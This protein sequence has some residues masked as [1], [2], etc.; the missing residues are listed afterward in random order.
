MH[1]VEKL[2]QIGI[3][4]NGNFTLKSGHSSN[5]YFNMKEITNH[6]T[7]MTDIC[8]ELSKLVIN[9]C[10]VC[11]A[12]VPMGA[13]PFATMVSYIKS[14][15]MMLVRAEKKEYGMEQQ[16]EH[17]N[18]KNVILIED[19]ITSGQSVMGVIDILKQHGI[20]VVQIITILD[21][22][23]GGVAMLKQLGYQVDCLFELSDFNQ[24][25]I[26][27]TMKSNPLIDK[28]L[29]IKHE[30]QSSIIA[31]LDCDNVY[32]VM[33]MVG[34][35]VCAV[36]LHGDIFE[37]LDIAKINELK[38]KYNFLVIEDRKFSDIPYICL[39]QLKLI[40]RYADIVTVHGICGELLIKTLS[41]EIGV[42]VVCNMSLKDNLMDRV[43][44]NK[45]LDF[46]IINLVGYVSQYKIDNYL[47]FTPG[48]HVD[49]QNDDLNQQYNL[50][51][52]ECDFHIV[53]RGLYEGDIM[54][55]I[56]KYI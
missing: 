23:A 27:Q 4:K 49:K 9:D 35:Y 33:E 1:L 20:N 51:S 24:I 29:N 25:I 21:R 17:N 48:I 11:I 38:H 31:S 30:K 53:G 3:V 47:T 14:L 52:N 56:K 12:G 54:T 34:P 10:E 37:T 50:P 55:N 39:K 36:K 43:Y 7:M 28:L 42:I 46:D 8:Y 41:D 6:P 13:I 19:V 5:V 44:Q 18:N 32:E 45:V 16:I 15:P 2:K 22:E 26:P 40:K